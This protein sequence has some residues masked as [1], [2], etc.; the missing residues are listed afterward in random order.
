MFSAGLS[1]SPVVI[2]ARNRWPSARQL[3]PK[4]WRLNPF[5]ICHLQAAAGEDPSDCQC[6][7]TGHRVV[8][9]NFQFGTEQPLAVARPH[10]ADRRFRGLVQSLRLAQPGHAFYHDL[11][12]NESRPSHARTP[13][14]RRSAA[15][16]RWLPPSAPSGRE[17]SRPPPVPSR[18]RST[19]A[20]GS[21]RCAD[22]SAMP[23]PAPRAETGPCRS[24]H[25]P[26]R[27][28]SPPSGSAACPAPN[29]LPHAARLHLIRADAG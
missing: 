13:A 4:N 22:G 10:P 9:P 14:P 20:P 23:A 7:V 29:T 25:W 18:S 21:P 19:P 11:S 17:A 2:V 12:R 28:A 6:E 16:W 24:R 26:A 1:G 15:Q 3:A 5:E 8:C 27:R